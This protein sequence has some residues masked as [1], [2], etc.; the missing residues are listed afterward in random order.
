MKN[1]LN[2]FAKGMFAIFIVVL[3]SCSSETEL[4][5]LHEKN[6]IINNYDE[7]QVLNGRLYFPNVSQFK[8]YYDELREKNEEDVADILEHKFYSKEFYSLKPIV[9]ARTEEIQF[10]RHLEK[11]KS[12]KSGLQQKSEAEDIQDDFDDLEDIFGEDIFTSFLNQEAEL[13]VAE[14]IYKYTDT[15]L[16]ISDEN[17]IS[18]LNAYLDEKQISRNLL[19]P[20]QQVVKDNYLRTFNPCGGYREVRYRSNSYDHSYQ[21]FVVKN[22]DCGGS[23]SDSDNSGGGSSNGSSSSAKTY[24]QYQTIANNLDLCS[25]ST[26]WFGNLFG[27]VKV[28]KDKYE[29]RR[30]VKIKYWNINFGIGYS[31]GVKVKHQY[32]GWTGFWRKQNTDNVVL[33]INSVSWKF[34]RNYNLPTMNL[35]IR[36]YVYDGKTYQT[37][38]AY[39]SAV[40]VSQGTSSPVPQIPFANNVDIVVEFFTNDFGFLDTEYKVRQKFY[41]L[42]YKSAKGILN[43]YNN[44]ALKKAI[45]IVHTNTETWVQYYDFSKDCSNCKKL[46]KVFDWGIATPS[47]TINLFEGYN[48]NNASIGS[49]TMDFNNPDLTGLSIFGMAKRKNQWHGKR[50]EF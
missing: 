33:G 20:T 19:N 11:I 45:A 5:N 23:G 9:N 27:T 10:S 31:I 30:R 44:R 40:F 6:E 41:K 36:Y 12:N 18:G 21:H 25:G 47:V 43:K 34:N 49:L 3:I 29:R 37:Q 32:R 13:Q 15:G 42:A 7:I 28:C 16:F 35:P 2:K 39:D 1:G 50:M 46:S 4:N 24:A 14:K 17:K 48:F 26:P 38:G 8:N 22:V